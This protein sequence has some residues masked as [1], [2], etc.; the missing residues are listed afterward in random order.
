MSKRLY[1]T[2]LDGTLLNEKGELS[3]F[4]VRGLNYLLA[5]GIHI[6]VASAR[7]LKS[8]QQKLKGVPLKLPV[9]GFNGAYVSDINASKHL[10]V[11][12]IEP[13][14]IDGIFNIFQSGV[15]ISAHLDGVEK[16]FYTEPLTSG[17][18]LYLKDRENHLKEKAHSIRN[19]DDISNW[20]I[21]AFTMID[22]Y[23]KINPVEEELAKVAAITSHT[24]QDMY[25][26]PWYWLSLHSRVAN[27]GKGIKILQ[28]MVDNTCE[29]VVFGDNINDIEMFEYSDQSF[30]VDNAISELKSIA[31]DTIGHH[32]EDSVIKKI[33]EMEGIDHDTL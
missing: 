12:A 15:L 18:Y 2:D 14:V 10:L 22:N 32:C 26:N 8:I 11:N 3:D 23:E 7:S 28:E 6:T 27:K 24:W 30:A 9:L 4:S 1:V 13:S 20:D 33:L 17:G 25:Y 16:L 19:L 31:T 21:M 5:K 29:I